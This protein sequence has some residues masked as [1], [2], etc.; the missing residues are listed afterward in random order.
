VSNIVPTDGNAIAFSRSTGQ[1]LNIAY[2]S[3]AA[4]SSGGFFPAGVNGNIR[5]S[6]ANA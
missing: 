3:K 5:T 1:V 6:A 4:I 2:L